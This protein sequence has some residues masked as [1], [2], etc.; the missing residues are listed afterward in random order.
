[1][2]LENDPRS[3]PNS[4][5]LDLETMNA[6]SLSPPTNIVEG[7]A[8]DSDSDA[9]S[10][11]VPDYYQ[12][13]YAVDDED[14]NEASSEDHSYGQ[15]SVANG[16]GFLAENEMRSLN[17]S[18][19]ED[20]ETEEAEEVEEERRRAESDSAIRRAFQDD[21]SRRNA[22]LTAE[23]TV[24]VMEAMRAVSFGGSAPDWVR[25]VPEDRWIDQLRRLR[26]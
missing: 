14:S 16:H 2:L 8:G 12:P 9:H 10:D 13:I 3:L 5:S 1:M 21:E 24:R 20:G 11:G 7:N 17:L 15:Q 18:D 23:N 26:Q 25:Y 4:I 22:P 19:S 6:A